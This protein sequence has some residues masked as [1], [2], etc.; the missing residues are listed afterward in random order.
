MYG[1]K[2]LSYCN[3]VHG[4]AIIIIIMNIDM[5]IFND[6]FLF[7]TGNCCDPRQ[8]DYDCKYKTEV[9]HIA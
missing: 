8:P 6:Y 3:G 1:F 4:T 2:F 5:S 7:V 9:N